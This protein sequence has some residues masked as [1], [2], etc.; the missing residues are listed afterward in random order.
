MEKIYQLGQSINL[1][2]RMDTSSAIRN[3][4]GDAACLRDADGTLMDDYSY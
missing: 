4:G 2:Y 3:N 1:F